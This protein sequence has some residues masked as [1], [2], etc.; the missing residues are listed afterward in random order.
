MGS[1]H[2]QG[3]GAFQLLTSYFESLCLTVL[4]CALGTG[5]E[6]RSSPRTGVRSGYIWKALQLHVQEGS[7]GAGGAGLQES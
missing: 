7:V 4:D 6:G 2:L 5:T 1:L 3:A